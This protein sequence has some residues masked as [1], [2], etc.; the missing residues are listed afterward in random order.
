MPV[1]VDSGNPGA[2]T[3]AGGG[4]RWRG[5]RLGGLIVLAVA[6]VLL[7][8]A[9]V[10]LVVRRH[11]A[12]T[13]APP[14]TPSASSTPP[15]SPTPTATGSATASGKGLPTSQVVVGGGGSGSLAGLP[16][17]YQHSF[18]G[19]VE[20]AINYDKAIYS[21]RYYDDD[22]RHQWNRYMYASHAVEKK[23]G[24]PDSVVVKTRKKRGLDEHGVP[25]DPTVRCYDAVY[26]RYGA[27]KTEVISA[28]KVVVTIWEPDVYGT[29]P[30]GT[31]DGVKVGWDYHKLEMSWVNGDWRMTAA[32]A[33]GKKAPKPKRAGYPVVSFAERAQLLGDGWHLPANA[34]ETPLPELNWP[35]Q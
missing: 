10:L 15:T 30:K 19:A 18:T 9:V 7:I 32:P 8:V 35:G 17:G 6:V 5:S 33:A 21:T 3:P 23:L 34:T 2:P 22:V 29:A 27:Y 24:I 16:I 14:A 13:T 20:A 4:P 25:T 28:D 31:L 26:P 12:G 11:D 1:R